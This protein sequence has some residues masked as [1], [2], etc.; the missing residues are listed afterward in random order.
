MKYVSINDFSLEISVNFASLFNLLSILLDLI[1]DFYDHGHLEE[2]QCFLEKTKEL[3]TTKCPKRVLTMISLAIAQCTH[4][5]KD[6]S[7]ALIHY[8]NVL[9]FDPVNEKSIIALAKIHMKEKNIEQ[10]LFY[11]DMFLRI[12]DDNVTASEEVLLIK[13]DLLAVQKKFI[14]ALD[15]YN[16]ILKSNPNNYTAMSNALFLLKKSG[17]LNDAELYFKNA[18]EKDPT[19]YSRAGFHYSKVRGMYSLITI[20]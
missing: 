16:L 12:A 8:K 10:A 1:E 17:K 5:Q 3:M 19:C 18:I 20:E 6:Y 14:D 9:D 13:C 11:C 4:V 2:V 15:C 7:T